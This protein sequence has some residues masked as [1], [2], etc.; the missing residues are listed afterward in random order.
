MSEE[1][2]LAEGFNDLALSKEVHKVLDDVGYETPT[3][4]QAKM[5]P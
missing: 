3:P 1:T 2:I 5:F 4:I